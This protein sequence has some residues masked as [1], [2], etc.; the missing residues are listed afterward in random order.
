MGESASP[1]SKVLGEQLDPNPCMKI[2]AILGLMWLFILQE[3]EA[4]P[5]WVAT[6]GTGSQGWEHSWDAQLGHPGWVHPLKQTWKMREMW[7]P[8]REGREGITSLGKS[9]YL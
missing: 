1:A 3:E 2:G 8:C 6:G 9:W 7:K 4:E 5:I